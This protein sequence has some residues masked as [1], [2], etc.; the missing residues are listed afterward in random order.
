MLSVFGKK[1]ARI[2]VD[3]VCSVTGGLTDDEQGGFR[4]EIGYVD[5]IFT[6]K[7]IDERYE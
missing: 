1:Y 5:Q 7:Q 4:A 6:L 2:L 3:R